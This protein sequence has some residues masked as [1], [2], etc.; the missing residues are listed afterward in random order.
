MFTGQMFIR[1]TACRSKL[2]IKLG[3]VTGGR[4]RSRFAVDLIAESPDHVAAELEDGQIVVASRSGDRNANLLPERAAR[5]HQDPVSQKAGFVGVVRDEDDR[6]ARLLPYRQEIGADAA[7]RDLVE[8]RE[9]LVHQEDAGLHAQGPHKGE[10]LGHASR[11][12]VGIV[13][14]ISRQARHGEIAGFQLAPARGR[15]PAAGERKI[16][17]PLRGK[18]WEQARLLEQVAD[19]AAAHAHPPLIDLVQPGEDVEQGRF[20]A[21]GRLQGCTG[22]PPR[23]P[24]DRDPSAR[25]GTCRRGP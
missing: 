21:A 18:P 7:R 12:L 13:I 8:P 20:A 11:D 14:A 24:P 19:A 6:L 15:H 1:A 9:R 2:S 5:H 17:I 23:R 3:S 22:T 4:D 10:A 16:E 25:H